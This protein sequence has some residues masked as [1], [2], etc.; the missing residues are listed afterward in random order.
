[1]GKS[2]E[3]KRRKENYKKSGS[4][5]SGSKHSSKRKFTKKFDNRKIKRRVAAAVK[6]QLENRDKEETSNKKDLQELAGFVGSLISDASDSKKPSAST[7]SGKSRSEL[8]MA[9]AIKINQIV[10]KSS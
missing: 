10:K 6:E 2:R 9:A 3:F 1:M 5:Q 4:K 7:M 8:A